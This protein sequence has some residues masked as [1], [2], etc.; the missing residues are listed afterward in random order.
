MCFCNGFMSISMILVYLEP[1]NHNPRDPYDKS[2]LK[3][4]WNNFINEFYDHEN[5]GIDLSSIHVCA[6]V[7]V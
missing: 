2:G 7:L 4:D 1:Q 6:L 3:Y 5:I